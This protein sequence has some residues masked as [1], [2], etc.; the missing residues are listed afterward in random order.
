[1]RS[2][3]QAAQTRGGSL[4]RVLVHDGWLTEADAMAT[5]I[6]CANANLALTAKLRRVQVFRL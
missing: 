2:R 5:Y 6:E 3:G 4:R 1:M